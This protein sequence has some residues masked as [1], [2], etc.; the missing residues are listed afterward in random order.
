MENRIT[1]TD[2]WQAKQERRRIVAVSCYDYTTAHVVS[3]APVEIVLVGDSAAQLMLGFDSTLPATMHFMVTITAA[4]RRGAPNVYLI[5]DMP[6]LSYHTGAADAVRNAGRFLTEGGAQM[7]KI[8]VTGAHVDTVRAVTDAGIAVMAHIGIRPQRISA[9]G[10]FRAEATTAE[11]A[12]ELVDLARR[13]IQAGAGAL[14]IEGTAAEVAQ[15]ISEQSQVP[16]ISC[17]SGPGCDGQILIAP[18]ILGLSQGRLPKFTKA[19]DQLGS[20]AVEA[21]Q[22]YA[23]EVKTGRFP[24]FEHSY[25][26]KDGE[27]QRLKDMLQASR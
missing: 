6:F 10:R 16:V 8:E 9:T 11:M 24:D 26:M 23:R 20:R 5:A 25:H 1:I 4:V 19:Y 17:G 15:I 27:L 13:M 7:V 21:I 2:L 18:D 14:L 3:Q 22:A 12:I